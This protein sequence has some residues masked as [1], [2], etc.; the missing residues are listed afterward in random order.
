M[1][2]KLENN[3]PF[4]KVAFE[5][6]AGDGKTYT[7]A[8]LAIGIH[9]LIQSKRPIAVFDTEKAFKALK[10][11][12]DKFSI[13]VMIAEGQRSLTALNQAIQWCEEGNA[14][15]LI[16]D[17]ITHVWE[18]F[19]EAYKT[20]KK[21]NTL[22][23]QDWGIIKPRWKKNFSDVF[24]M[25]HV[26]IIFTGRAGYAYDTEV[27]PKTGKRE[28][29]K[30]G[31]KMKVENETAFEPD[32]LVLMEKVQKTLGE[33][34]SVHRLATILKDRTTMIDGKTFQNPSFEDF[35]PAI[36]I[37]L[38]GELR[39]VHGEE[40]PDTFQDFEEKLSSRV[41]ECSQ[42][43]TEIEGSFQLI[44]LSNAT[45]DRQFKAYILNKVFGVNALASVGEL[46]IHQVKQGQKVIA[47]YT[48][49]YAAYLQTC[50]EESLSPDANVAAQMLK[51]VLEDMKQSIES[52]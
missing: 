27:N 41:K 12:F 39:E 4:A 35:Y 21:R 50:M 38:D 48:D 37:L 51:E 8:Q 23:F 45:K 30:A 18:N 22:Q 14:D 9:R 29:H 3:R 13:E 19:I 28:I 5:G 26:H 46:P 10:H 1:F 43:L 20:E 42:V 31:I 6:F 34:K 52:E 40:L 44:G 36:K 7:A 17:S 49:A 25:A 24:V 15:I 16:I 33:E 47:S 11:I 32:L 2:T